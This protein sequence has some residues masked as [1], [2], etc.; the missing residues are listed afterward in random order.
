MIGLVD[1]N[2]GN[3]GSISNMLR[4][5][6][7]NHLTSSDPVTLKAASKLILPGVGAFD[8]VMNR[9]RELDLI[10]F[11]EDQVITKEKPFLGI[12]VGMQILADSSEEGE[13]SG[14]GWIPGKVKK[15]TFPQEQ[16]ELRVPHMGWNKIQPQFPDPI[17]QSQDPD[18]S[19]FYFVHSYYF[20]VNAAA[21][22]LAI[23]DYGM[24]FT[25]AVKRKNIYGVQ[26]HPEKSHKQG[27][28]LFK[29]FSE[30]TC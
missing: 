30:L 27:L 7:I 6:G 23:T 1:L 15:F 21:D 26:F 16:K 28:L 13:L 5:L 19:F 12:C 4:R 29:N 11:L 9:I 3:I 8:N 24:D 10:P 25:S 2:T 14:L 20:K 22:S 17:F 18:D